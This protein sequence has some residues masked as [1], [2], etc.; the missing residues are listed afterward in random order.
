MKTL[1]INS[2]T[3]LNIKN[4]YHK[5]MKVCGLF[6]SKVVFEANNTVTDIHSGSGLMSSIRRDESITLRITGKDESQAAILIK[7]CI[8]Y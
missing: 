8:G 1:T 2:G 6:D 3:A 5:F 7:E 4:R